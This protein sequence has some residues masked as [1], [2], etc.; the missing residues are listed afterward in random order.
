M[1]TGKAKRVLI[2]PASS[3]PLLLLSLPGIAMVPISFLIVWKSGE[4][5]ML[6]GLFIGM[7]HGVAIVLPFIAARSVRY[8]LHDRDFYCQL[9]FWRRCIPFADIRQLSM[10]SSQI[11]P[12]VTS[13]AFSFDLVEILYE[14]DGKQHRLR[15]APKYQPAF[16]RQLK[17]LCPQMIVS[18]PGVKV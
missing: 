15:I 12:P 6:N 17:A 2:E 8:E 13:L 11:W 18:L 1:N 7:V 16:A 5:T 3:W 9:F 10:P 14:Q 4:L